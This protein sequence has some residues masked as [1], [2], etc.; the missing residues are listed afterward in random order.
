MIALSEQLAGMPR[1]QIVKLK[2]VMEAENIQTVPQN[3]SDFIDMMSEKKPSRKSKTILESEKI[4][5]F[6]Q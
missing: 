6:E 4:I 1:D 5:P 2:A 3:V